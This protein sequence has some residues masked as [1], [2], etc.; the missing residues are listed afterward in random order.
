MTYRFD[1]KVRVMKKNVYDYLELSTLSTNGIGAG[2]DF[3]FNYESKEESKHPNPY[4]IWG[5][6]RFLG[7]HIVEV[8]E[9]TKELER[10]GIWRGSNDNVVNR[11][12]KVSEIKISFKKWCKALNVVRAI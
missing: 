7:D 6:A 5:H 10:L 2:R 1:D 8:S 3:I 12:R 4:C 9:V 11:N